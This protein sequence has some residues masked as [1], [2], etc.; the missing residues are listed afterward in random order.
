MGQAMLTGWNARN[1]AP[2]AVVAPSLDAGHHAV[3]R[4][5]LFRDTPS[6][7]AALL[8]A[9]TRPA[10]I[11][12]A[13]KPQ[14]A[15]AVLPA[16][17]PLLGDGAAGPVVLSIMAGRTL[18]ALAAQLPAGSRLVRSM[19]NTPAAIGRGVTVAVAGAGVDTVQRNLCDRLLRAAGAVE[20]VENE[21]LLDAVTA[22]SGS[23]PAYVFLLAELLERAGTAQGLPPALARTLARATVSGAGALLDALPDDAD[24]LRRAVTSPGGT[25]E[26][27]LSVL[28]APENWPSAVS[29]AVRA[30]TERSRALAG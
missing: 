11:V 22:V 10:A 28:M 29:D 8:E 2:S 15:D 26:Q 4:H 7:V 14:K 12:L 23:G 5:D 20:W 3:S 9:G 27:A 16:L 6:A 13:V 19:P 25:T 30:A 17:A 21:A 1:L 18:A 24:A